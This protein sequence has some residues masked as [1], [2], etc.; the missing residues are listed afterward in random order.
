MASGDQNGRAKSAAEAGVR[1]SSRRDSH[2]SGV[3]TR[4]SQ[5]SGI[6]AFPRLVTVARE[7]GAGGARIAGRV[8]A[9][10][11]LQLWDYELI[12]H[13]ARKA[14][15]DLGVVREIDERH[16]DLIDDVV[17]TSL[18]GARLTGSRYRA[19]LTRTVAE[20]AE[21]GGAVI[22][23]R[24]ANF[25]VRAEDALRVHVVCPLRE[26]IE[27]YARRAQIEWARAERIVRTKDDERERFV[28]QLCGET[29]HD[30][31]HYDLTL[32]TRD[33]NEETAAQLIVTAYRARFRT[34]PTRSDERASTL[35]ASW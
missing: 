30:C 25:L 15:T 31:G 20:L 13:L 4:E 34:Q 14:D 3:R 11:G 28:R 17:A 16:R 24:G 8:A 33:L 7:F 9:E 5:P 32:N 10:L 12:T 26:R 2:A 1:P 29:S 35:S 27:R 19:L 18:H 23:G 21:R 6:E 22:V